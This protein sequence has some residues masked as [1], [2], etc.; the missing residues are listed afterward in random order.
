MR[1]AA[2]LRPLAL[3]AGCGLQD[4]TQNCTWQHPSCGCFSEAHEAPPP[5]PACKTVDPVSSHMARF[6][7]MHLTCLP[8]RVTLSWRKK[9]LHH[10]AWL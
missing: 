8:D 10:W 7:S 2:G 9:T 4:P 6:I 5:R 3:T 1:G